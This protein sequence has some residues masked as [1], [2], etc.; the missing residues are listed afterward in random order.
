MDDLDSDL[1]GSSLG[2]KS[3]PKPSTKT[4]SK[5]AEKPATLS[6]TTKEKQAPSKTG[7]GSSGVKDGLGDTH[8]KKDSPSKPDSPRR[9]FNINKYDSMGKRFSVA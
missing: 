7:T 1:F 9:K 6:T 5:P 2:K 3:T 8:P 4:T